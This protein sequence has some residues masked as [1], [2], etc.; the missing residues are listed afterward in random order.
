MTLLSATNTATAMMFT[1]SVMA[2]VVVAESG[3]ISRG[4]ASFETRLPRATNE[5]IDSV[6]ASKK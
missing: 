3:T 6:V 1:P 2:A 4:N 5:N